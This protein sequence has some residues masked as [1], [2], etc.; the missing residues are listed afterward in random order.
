MRSLSSSV[1]V[2]LDPVDVF[3]LRIGATSPEKKNKVVIRLSAGSRVSLVL[4][5]HLTPFRLKLFFPAVRYL[6]FFNVHGFFFPRC[7][8]E[9]RFC[10][11]AVFDPKPH[12]VRRADEMTQLGYVMRR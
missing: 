4:S 10:R 8:N 3:H 12:R 1:D 11:H 2:R 6:L 7:H 5:S 9:I